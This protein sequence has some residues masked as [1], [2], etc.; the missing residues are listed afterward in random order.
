MRYNQNAATPSGGR[1]TAAGRSDWSKEFPVVFA[2]ESVA[3]SLLFRDISSDEIAQTGYR[4]TNSAAP[5]NAV[6]HLASMTSTFATSTQTGYAALMGFATLQ[7]AEY[8][9][10]YAIKAAALDTS[11]DYITDAVV[12]ELATPTDG[13][14]NN[15]KPQ[16]ATVLTL[17]SGSRFGRAN[18]GRMYLPHCALALPTDESRTSVTIAD[19]FSSSAATFLDA[20]NTL[21]GALTSP[22]AIHV[23]SSVGTGES[24]PVLQVGVG[25]VT[26]TQRRRRNRLDEEIQ[27]TT[28]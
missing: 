15:V 12:F 22:G 6:A 9:Q 19:G 17:W 26:D 14:A 21:H 25:R 10:L 24:K 20:Q 7:W 16:L 8:S 28:L 11:G 27:Y 5:F 18:F 1:S 2:Q 4:V 3:V 23:M 13:S